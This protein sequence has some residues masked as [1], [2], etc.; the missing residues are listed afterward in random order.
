M[1]FPACFPLPPS[2]S[3]TLSSCKTLPI[4]SACWQVCQYVLWLVESN[5]GLFLNARIYFFSQLFKNIQQATTIIIIM[6]TRCV[7]PHT[8]K[9]M[10]VHWVTCTFGHTHLTQSVCSAQNQHN[11]QNHESIRYSYSLLQL[12]SWMRVSPWWCFGA[13][14]MSLVTDPGVD[15][16]EKDCVPSPK[17]MCGISDNNP[18]L[19]VRGILSSWNI[20]ASSCKGTCAPS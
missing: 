19:M 6:Y 17:A 15:C 16:V 5:L 18:L 12:F 3:W 4:R 20:S 1:S 11:H 2:L 9:D 8:F 14:A 7:C 13:S 10:Q